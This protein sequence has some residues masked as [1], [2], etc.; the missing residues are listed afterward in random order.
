MK[1]SE[2]LE[3]LSKVSD[4]GKRIIFILYGVKLHRFYLE[5]EYVVLSED[6]TVRKLASI[7][8][9]ADPLCDVKLP[10]NRHSFII[11]VTECS[12]IYVELVSY[13]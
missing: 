3:T 6:M 9:E 1:V 4:K 7:L 11:K 12:K 5:Y 8:L 2:L 10:Y 13:G